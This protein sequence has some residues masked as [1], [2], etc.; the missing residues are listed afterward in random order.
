MTGVTIG[1]EPVRQPAVRALLEQA[2]AY[3]ESLYPAESNHHLD[4]SGL[5]RP[6]VSFFVARRDGAAVGCGA[7]VVNADGS[8]ELKSLFVDPAAR[9]LRIGQLLVEAIEAHAV[10][11]GVTVLRLETGIRQPAALGL[12]EKAGYRPINLFGAY[13]PDPLSVFMEKTLG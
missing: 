5:D 7:V 9:G 8:G 2:C 1:L 12:Y 3:S 11:L 13:K 10:A 4:E 6:Q